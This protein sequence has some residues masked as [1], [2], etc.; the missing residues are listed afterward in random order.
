MKKITKKLALNR[1]VVRSL[2]DLE[3]AVAQGGLPNPTRSACGAVCP[4]PSLACS[5]GRVRP[6][7]PARER[8]G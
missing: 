8:G 3:M 6:S 5:E 1:E 2:A 7:S 4:N